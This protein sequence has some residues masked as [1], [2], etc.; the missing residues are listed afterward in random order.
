MGQNEN[1]KGPM[2]SK[3][4]IRSKERAERRRA[5]YEEKRQTILKNLAKIVNDIRTEYDAAHD[6]M[7]ATSELLAS[8]F[9]CYGHGLLMKP[10]YA[11]NLPVINY[12]DCAKQ[13]I[14]NHEDTWKAMDSI[15]KGVKE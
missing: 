2:E 6:Q 8:V 7:E 13:I 11:H 9:A 5:E 15:L 1:E 14:M 10:V 12:E 4:W 3:A